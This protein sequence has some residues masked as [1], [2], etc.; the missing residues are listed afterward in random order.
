MQKLEICPSD[1][2]PI[3]GKWHESLIPNFGTNDSNK[4]LLNAGKFQRYS[5]YRF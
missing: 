1:F 5:F 3:S 2:Y 4:V